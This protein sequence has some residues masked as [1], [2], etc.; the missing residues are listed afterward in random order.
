MVLRVMPSHGYCIHEDYTGNE[1]YN[2]VILY[3]RGEA[4]TFIQPHTF[5]MPRAVKWGHRAVYVQMEL[6]NKTAKTYQ[7]R[8]TLLL[9][10]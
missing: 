8:A 9:Y 2:H 10:M 4:A 1:D 5:C 6:C 7:N 3:N